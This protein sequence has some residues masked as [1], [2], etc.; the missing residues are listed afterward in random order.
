[1]ST[2]PPHEVVLLIAHGSRN[3]A[4]AARHHELC[5]AVAERSGAHVRPAFLEID[6]PSVG[7]AIDRAVADGARRVVLLP[8]F[9][10][11]GNHVAVDLPALAG[12]G[13]GRHPGVVVEVEEHIGA[14]PGLV[15]LV[16]RRVRTAVGD[17]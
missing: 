3:P 14:D 13:R 6:E 12:T 7:D 1:M 11:P 17:G 8:H 15:D 16:A 10:H 9:L 4:G 2:P 5:R